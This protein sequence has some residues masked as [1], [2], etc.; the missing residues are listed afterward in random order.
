MTTLML[1]SYPWTAESGSM[2]STSNPRTRT[3][4]FDPGV[5]L[6][7]VSMIDYARLDGSAKRKTVYG[8]NDASTPVFGF[9]HLYF[10]AMNECKPSDQTKLETSV[11]FECNYFYSSKT[12]PSLPITNPHVYHNSEAALYLLMSAIQFSTSSLRSSP[13]NAA[14]AQALT[15]HQFP[16]TR[17]HIDSLGMTANSPILRYC[18]PVTDVPPQNIRQESS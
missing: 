8:S 13:T 18:I 4:V 10:E 14:S 15:Q 6:A 12:F 16:R 11:Q 3:L 5:N 9:G 1:L 2:T 17:S 7:M